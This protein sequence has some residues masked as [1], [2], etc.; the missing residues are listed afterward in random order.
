MVAAATIGACWGRHEK[1]SRE[2]DSGTHADRPGACGCLAL[3]FTPPTVGPGGELLEGFL[4]GGQ[5][6]SEAVCRLLVTLTCPQPTKT[7]DAGTEGT[8][9][10]RETEGH[11]GGSIWS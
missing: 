7:A 8:C 4:V 9:T 10:C 5:A 3:E 2:G 6:L 1:A 11:R